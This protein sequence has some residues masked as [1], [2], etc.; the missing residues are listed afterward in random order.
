MHADHQ[1]ELSLKHER[2][3]AELRLQVHALQLRNESLVRDNLDRQAEREAWIA[4]FGHQA[5]NQGVQVACYAVGD[6]ITVERTI[7]KDGSHRWAVRSD[8]N[9]LNHKGEWAWEP[10][11]SSRGSQWLTDFRFDSLRDA[12]DAA[13]AA[14]KRPVVYS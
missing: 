4:R 1:E 6:H 13:V 8:G 5:L 11:P 7:Q 10:M 2:E 12:L 3:L 9:V 14:S